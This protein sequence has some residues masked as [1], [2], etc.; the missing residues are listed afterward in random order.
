QAAL[1]GGIELERRADPLERQHEAP[2]AGAREAAREVLAAPR[3]LEVERLEPLD[4]TADMG[5]PPC[6]HRADGHEPRSAHA[7]PPRGRTTP[8]MAGS[9]GAAG[10]AACVQHGASCS[11]ALSELR[12]S[13][14]CAAQCRDAGME[15]LAERV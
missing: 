14:I 13:P 9:P 10:G 12:R 11:G 3:D 15:M 6:S 1:L 4:T 2:R 8:Q 7:R 5:P